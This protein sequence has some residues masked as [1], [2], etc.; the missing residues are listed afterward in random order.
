MVPHSDSAPMHTSV[1]KATTHRLPFS[2]I[3]MSS[4]S[5]ENP[6]RPPM[7]LH[8]LLPTLPS[9]HIS[10][11]NYLDKQLE[12]IDKFY[13]EREKEAQT[14]SKALEIQLR[15]LKD[16][17]KIFYV[18]DFFSSFLILFIPNHANNPKEA[19]PKSGTFWSINLKSN[20]HSLP[21]SLP[22]T[23]VNPIPTTV[24]TLRQRVLV[25]AIAK[26]EADGSNGRS[27]AAAAEPGPSNGKGREHM[28]F[29]NHQ[30]RHT[31]SQAAATAT[32]VSDAPTFTHAAR[33]DPEEYQHAKKK[34][35]RAVLENYR[36]V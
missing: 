21:G 28:D 15:E 12:K 5:L 23:A 11:F 9:I 36:W 29:N 13:S 16:H 33:L 18:R 24:S 19:H 25:P 22:L 26:I 4:R 2:P 20:L 1:R 8:T 35:K 27:R 14:R 32:G 31:D 30:T 10:F 17:R 34:L 3:P 6:N 7:T